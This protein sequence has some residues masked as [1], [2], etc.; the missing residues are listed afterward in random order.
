MD[1]QSEEFNRALAEGAWLLRTNQPA[2][3]VDKLLPL[4]E[5]APSN[6]DVAIN[7]GGRTFCWQSGT[8]PCVC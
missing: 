6:L 2:A 1:R 8:K 3:A 7:L 5:Q 4:Y